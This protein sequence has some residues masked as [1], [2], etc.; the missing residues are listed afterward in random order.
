YN[1][2]KQNRL[3]LLASIEDVE[4][5]KNDISL[6]IAAMYLQILF[7]RD[8]LEMSEK[9]MEITK[10]QIERT[11]KLVEAGSVPEGSLMEVEAQL[12]SEELAVVNNRNQLDIS[13]LTMTQLL[14]LDSAEGF[15]IVVP[16]L[17]EL[18]MAAIEYSIDD[19]F[20]TATANMPQIRSAELKLQS[21]EKGLAIAKGGR[22]PRLSM[23]ASWGTGYSSSYETYSIDSTS[24]TMA[25]I[26]L[27]TIGT[28]TY[29]V[30]A[31]Q[32]GFVSE[33]T[34]FGDQFR[35]NGNYS[36]GFNLS[37]PIFN[38]LQVSKSVSNA[39]INM[40]NNEYALELA[41]N[42]LYKDIQQSY[43]DVLAALKKYYSS[44]KALE[45]IQKSFDYTKEKYDVGLVTFVDY[46][47]ARQNLVKTE[48]DLIQAK[49]E[50]IFKS[51]IL[52]FYR[53]IPINL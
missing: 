24:V 19:I 30:Y 1:T 42:Q 13:M 5:M 15:D 17:P 7:N 37:I 21:A 51:K 47:I 29:Y 2:I 48:S 45:S 43:T 16:E 6:N 35:N 31:P 12:A 9:Q 44:K 33:T 22:S 10:L 39:K 27:T 41:R 23:T 36:L 25:M 11:A 8:M 46:N 38:G 32:F 18:E 52:D 20:V 49:Y 53:G 34:P 40:L 3:N 4:K 26:G 14:E 50:Y 28:E